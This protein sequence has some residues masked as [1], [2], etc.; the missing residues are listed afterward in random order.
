LG[1]VTERV[2]R[3]AP[4]PVLVLRRHERE[5]LGA[6]SPGEGA[7]EPRRILVPIDF[8]PRSLSALRFAG[9]FAATFGGIVNV[10]YSLRP[11]VGFLSDE[12]AY[13]AAAA[14]AEAIYLAEKALCDFVPK[15]VAG[16]VIVRTGPPL[17]E[18]PLA[19]E[20]GSFD[21]IVCASRSD[22]PIQHAL[23]GSTA[24]GIVRHAS[25]PVLVVNARAGA[26]VTR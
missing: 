15:E 5:F 11:F 19:A 9:R 3:A 23:L 2:I 14:E 22:K 24:E 17:A 25:C 1:S 18:I 4:C 8:S 10:M 21:L 26:E 12:L 20:E 7:R 6:V 13:G 16:G